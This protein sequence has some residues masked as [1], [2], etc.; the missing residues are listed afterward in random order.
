MEGIFTKRVHEAVKGIPVGETRTYQDVARQAGNPRAYHAV[1]N[2]L[3]KNYDPA[4]PCHR[5]VRSDGT[6][7]GYNR[8]EAKKKAIL[9]E[10]RSL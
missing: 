6:V 5:V 10:E 3:N 7:G 2:I 9:E 1:G 8:G 4:I